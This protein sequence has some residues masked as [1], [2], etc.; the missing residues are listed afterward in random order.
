MWELKPRT[1]IEIGTAKGGSAL[2]LADQLSIYGVE[3]FEV[4]SYDIDDAADVA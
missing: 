4:H 2:W 1:V 3:G